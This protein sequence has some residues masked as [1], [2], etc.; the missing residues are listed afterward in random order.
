V[1]VTGQH[2]SGGCLG[3]DR[4]VLALAPPP[5]PVGAVDLDH[6]DALAGQ[7]LGEPVAVAA[8]AL[9]PGGGDLAVAAGPGDQVAVGGIGGAKR[10]GRQPATEPI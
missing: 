9:H 4:V 5:G 10:R 6:A 7:V 2:G 8:G 3:V 1:G